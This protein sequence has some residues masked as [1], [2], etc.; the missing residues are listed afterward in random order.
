MNQ[1]AV[2]S[3]A[4]LVSDRHTPRRRSQ[5]GP[6]LAHTSRLRL[7]VL[8]LA[9]IVVGAV[10]TATRL[11]DRRRA[12]SST[13]LRASEPLWVVDAGL[14]TQYPRIGLAISDAGGR[15]LAFEFPAH[16]SP[17]ATG[18]AGPVT[19]GRSRCLR[20]RASD[21]MGCPQ[22]RIGHRRSWSTRRCPGSRL[23]S[24]SA[25]AIS[26]STSRAATGY[27]CPTESHRQ[28]PV[29]RMTIAAS[30]TRAEIEERVRSSG[31]RGLIEIAS[32]PGELT[33]HADMVLA[34]EPATGRVFVGGSVAA[35]DG[36]RSPSEPGWDMYRE[37]ASADPREPRT[38]RRSSSR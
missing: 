3:R 29:L 34:V 31:V 26:M 37:I 36:P 2:R 19:T 13:E 5:F 9:L 17:T 7:L 14:A 18:T 6:T 12:L 28:Q 23:R 27:R 30:A 4:T 21:G 38:H 10:A 20:R 22:R 33:Q 25:I 8:T 16:V 35:G 11:T 15:V 24:A 32:L 1:T